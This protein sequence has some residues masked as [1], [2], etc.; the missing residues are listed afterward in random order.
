MLYDL[1]EKEIEKIDFIKEPT[2][3]KK[4]KAPKY[5]MLNYVDGYHSRSDA[6]HP[7]N[8]RDHYREKFY[9]A[10]DVMVSSVNDRFDQPSFKVFEKLESL[11]IKALNGQDTSSE[12]KFVKET[13]GTDIDVD[14]LVVELSTFNVLLKDLLKDRSIEHFNDLIKHAHQKPKLTVE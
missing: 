5:S 6:H 1:C 10:V 12:V 8:P 7:T 2:L 3:K 4:R 9:Q 13:F 11:M 14:D